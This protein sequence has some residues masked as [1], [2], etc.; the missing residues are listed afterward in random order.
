[1]KCEVVRVDA[2]TSKPGKGNP[3]GVVFSGDSYSKEQMQ[4]IAKKVGFNETVFICKSDLAAL[5][6]R[7]FTPG[8]ET[9][10]CGHATMGAIFALLNGQENCQLEIETAAGVLPVSYE[11]KGYQIT[12]QQ[13]RLKFIDFNGDRSALCQSLG[14]QKTDLHAKLPIK[15]GNTGSWT[16]LLPV[17][18]E[19]I[20]DTMNPTPNEFPGILKEIPKSSIHPFAVI[21]K[22]D[23]TFTA[24]HFSSP[25]AGTKE[26]SVTG[27]ASGVMGAYA[28]NHIYTSGERNKITV[29]Q[30]KQVQSEG[31][32]FVQVEI[33]ATGQQEVSISGTACLNKTLEVEV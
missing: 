30:G 10:L 24:R 28:L 13:A 27:T 20:L 23:G 14:I 8:Y 4:Q 16:L 3:A 19:A 29:T 11:A 33:D 12:M 25:A 6:L 5:K 17:K 26:D 9:P 18:N 2:F 7:Y 1:M 22:Q 21:S 15:Y 32:V 31:T